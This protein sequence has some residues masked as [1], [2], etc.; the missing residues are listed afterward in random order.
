VVKREKIYHGRK[1]AVLEKM[2]RGLSVR[3]GKGSAAEGKELK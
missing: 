1:V 3:K 2:K